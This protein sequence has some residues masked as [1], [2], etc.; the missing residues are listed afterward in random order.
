MSSA[1]LYSDR[2]ILEPNV[3]YER[4]LKYTDGK[5]VRDGQ[6]VMFTTMQNEKFFLSN[7]DAN[8]LHHLNLAPN[9]PFKICKSVNG[10][11]VDYLLAKANR[12]PRR[13]VEPSSHVRES[14]ADAES[15]QL[16]NQLERSI[17]ETRRPVEQALTSS[18]PAG[19]YRTS[20]EPQT[21]NQTVPLSNGNKTIAAQMAASYIAAIDA[22]LMARDYAEAKELDFRPEDFLKE[23]AHSIFIEYGKAHDR[24]L[25]YGGG[26]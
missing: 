13:P 7:E 4:V 1:A 12:E 18:R 8:R 17:A 25:R 22:L 24:A 16:T 21:T 5:S 9:E 26:R 19:E 2:L 10:R 23:C 20:T 6:S 15:R 11:N 3:W 14:I